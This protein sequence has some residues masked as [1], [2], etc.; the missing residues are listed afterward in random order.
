MSSPLDKISADTRI[1]TMNK[2]ATL[3]ARIK[4]A[5]VAAGLSVR[6]AAEGAGVSA[7]AWYQWEDGAQ[8]MATRLPDIARTLLVSLEHLVG[9][10]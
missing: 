2:Q 9:S 3:S 1:G 6:S 10:P 7:A 4:H 5:R 8:P